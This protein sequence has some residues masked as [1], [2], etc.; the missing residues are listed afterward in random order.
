MKQQTLNLNLSDV[1]T[2]SDKVVLPTGNY[3]VKITSAEVA[4]T[5]KGGHMI[6]AGF[7]VTAGEHKGA[8]VT[9]RFNIVNDN[10]DAVRIGLQ[11]IKTILTVGGHKNPNLLKHT[12]ELVGLELSIYIEEVDNNW[13][14]K[15]GEE[16]ESTQNEFKGYMKLEAVE[17]AEVEEDEEE[18]EEAPAPKKK[19]AKKKV[20]T[21]KKSPVKEEDEEDEEEEKASGGFPWQK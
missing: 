20:A 14:N 16:V 17:E 8:T 13:T 3:P 10:E 6:V 7:T 2:M 18:E 11:Q 12:G 4:E 5:K 19:V 9:N 15:D 1:S 21:K